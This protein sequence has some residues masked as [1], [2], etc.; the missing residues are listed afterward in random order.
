MRVNISLSN[1]ML[2]AL[3]RTAKEL[4]LSRSGAIAH[5]TLE[6]ELRTSRYADSRPGRKRAKR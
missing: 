1:A 3:D 2:E 4:S 5:L 6:R